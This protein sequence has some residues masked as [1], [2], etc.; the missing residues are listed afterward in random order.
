MVTELKCK[1]MFHTECIETYLKQYNHKC[2]VCR[3]EVGNVIYNF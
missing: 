3:S 2:P 1:H